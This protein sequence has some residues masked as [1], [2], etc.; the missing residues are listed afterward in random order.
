MGLVH[1]LPWFFTCAC[2]RRHHCYADFS[3]AD[4]GYRLQR[5]CCALVPRLGL[6]EPSFYFVALSTL[7]LA[8]RQQRELDLVDE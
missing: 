6:S 1:F 4:S 5:I 7:W 8:L 2:N 3:E